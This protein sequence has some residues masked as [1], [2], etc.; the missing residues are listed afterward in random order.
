MVG[1]ELSLGPPL[2]LKLFIDAQASTSVPSTLKCSFDKS[3]FTRGCA[4]TADRN[5]AAISPSS[6][7]SRQREKVE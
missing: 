6:R 7:R 2:A 3:R 4:S 5:R 1:P